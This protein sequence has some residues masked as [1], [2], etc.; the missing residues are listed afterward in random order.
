MITCNRGCGE[1]N[2]QWKIVNDQYKLFQ[3]NGLLH[4]CNDGVKAH[5]VTMKEKTNEILKEL[6]LKDVK[7]IPSPNKTKE[8]AKPS[9]TADIWVK[10][11]V[12][13]DP[14][15]C[16]TIT[17]TASGIAITGDDKHNPIYLPKVA[18]PEL[19]KALVEFIC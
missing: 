9:N 10:P 13:K 12:T 6:G 2:L 8:P 4:M 3:S 7:E 19:V 14:A 17:S 16:F 11:K 18:V 5:K 15:L 1:T